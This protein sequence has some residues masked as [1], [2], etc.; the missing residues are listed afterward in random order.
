[1][2]NFPKL[3]I[4]QII[5]TLTLPNLVHFTESILYTEYREELIFCAIDESIGFGQAREAM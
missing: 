2:R 5:S 3:R 4:Q 1:M